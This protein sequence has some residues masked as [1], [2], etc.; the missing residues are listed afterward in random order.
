MTD[1]F[2]GIGKVKLW[3][4]GLAFAEVAM[5]RRQPEDEQR[6]LQNTEPFGECGL[7]HTDFACPISLLE[8]NVLSDVSLIPVVVFT[9]A[10]GLFSP[11]VM[12]MK[13]NPD[14]SPLAEEMVFASPP[15]LLAG[16]VDWHQLRERAANDPSFADAVAALEL[17][18][19]ALLDAPLQPFERDAGGGRRFLNSAR[20]ILGN[21]LRLGSAWHLTRHPAFAKRLEEQVNLTVAAPHWNPSHFLDTAETALAVALGLTW[22]NEAIDEKTKHRWQHALIEKALR[23]SFEGPEEQRNWMNYANNWLQ[24]CHSGLVAAALVTA[25]REPEL[26]AQTIRRAIAQQSHVAHNYAPDGAY[27]EGPIYWDYGTTFA[28]LLV[29]FLRRNFEGSDFGLLEV[30]GFME[31]GAY[32]RQMVMPSGKYFSYGDSRVIAN[33]TPLP[34]W[35]AS[36]LERASIAQG[37]FEATVS[38]LREEAR[39]GQRTLL[40]RFYP[41]AFLWG[42]MQKPSAVEK[43][44]ALPL[45]WLG[46]G[47]NPVAV[48]RTAWNDPRA[49]AF[50]IKGGG[51]GISHAHMDAGSFVYEAGGVRWAEDLGMHDYQPLEVKGINLWDGRQDGDRWKIFRSGPEGHNLIRFGDQPQI[52]GP[53]A[54]DLRMHTT[55]SGWEFEVDL[56]PV[57]AGQVEGIIRKARLGKDGTLSIH[58]HWTG[59]STGSVQWQWITSAGVEVDN[60]RI[61]LRS[62]DLTLQLLVEASHPFEIQVEEAND[63]QPAF[64][65][66]LSGIRRIRVIQPGGENNGWIKVAIGLL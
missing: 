39:T 53:L 30:P 61:S 35:F 22:L 47:K 55:E 18:A 44:N 11:T 52:A 50:A 41:L 43:G 51:T 6:R 63:L 10:L 12:S 32:Y 28:A 14:T 23:P 19:R 24:V 16:Q 57:Y 54:E 7:G 40:D 1:P 62:G 49:A 13:A 42:A 17:S 27:L 9:L 2:S 66:P 38:A 48:A 29:E 5:I 26:A 37:E 34:L 64:E 65:D 8:K 36:E 3:R 15:V 33:A 20:L 25:D 60:D 31:S 58:D 45:A 56:E 59:N 21:V 46:R 4:F